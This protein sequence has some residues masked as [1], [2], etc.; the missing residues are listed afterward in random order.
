MTTHTPSST[1]DNLEDE[2]V[3]LL[4]R[5]L[6]GFSVDL[7]PTVNGVMNRNALRKGFSVGRGR[8][9]AVAEIIDLVRQHSA[10]SSQENQS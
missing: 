8:S 4:V 10:I 3:H 9:I 5:S 2:V 1:R 7:V 6:G